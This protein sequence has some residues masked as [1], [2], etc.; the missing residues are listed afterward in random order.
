MKRYDIINAFISS[1]KYKDF[2]EI[3]TDRGETYYAVKAEV[4]VS[5]DPDPAT[6]P[7]HCMTSD[8]FFAQ[9]KAH[10]DIIFIDGLHE[11]NQVYRDIR[12]AL[13]CLAPGG[14]I[15][16]HDCI[17]T[18]EAMQAHHDTSQSGYAWTGD[19]WKA[20]VK[21]RSESPYETYTVNTDFGC[22]IIDTHLSK[23]SDTSVLPQDMDKMTYSDFASHRNEWMNI[24]GGVLL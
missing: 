24:K 7:T 10:F 9:N 19:V 5:V 17:P 21:Y 16:L 3:G 8:D 12:N 18:T 1:R 4:K 15:I 2:L 14:T 11:C 13:S 6:N 20:F 23:W 22:G